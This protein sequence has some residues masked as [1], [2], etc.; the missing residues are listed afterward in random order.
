M[1]IAILYVGIAAIGYLIAVFLTSQ[2]NRFGWI[3]KALTLIVACLIF[4]MGFR[5]G[6]NEEV[7]ANLGTIGIQSLIMALVSLAVC[8]AFMGVTRR[9]MGYDRYGMRG[10]ERKK[11]DE[12]RKERSKGTPGIRR[13]KLLTKST[14][15]YLVSVVVGFF[16]G[17]LMVL[18][19]GLVSYETA[20]SVSAT[21]ITYGLYAMVFLV[22]MDMG[23]DGSL[24]KVF[25]Q[26]G[27]RA[28]V[29]PVATAM[30]TFAGAPPAL[31][32]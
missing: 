29:F 1:K 32:I 23:F 6:E 11:R 2:K 14:V 7:V 5:I 4:L 10:E 16:A 26:T 18:K 21:F 8:I 3:G 27:L 25:R 30:A 31:R 12:E 24:P 13:G 20:S 19:F 22:G 15:R 28:L 9:L 17:Y